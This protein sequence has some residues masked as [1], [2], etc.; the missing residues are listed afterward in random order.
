VLAGLNPG[1]GSLALYGTLAV[2]GS[3]V[4]YAVASLYGQKRVARVSGPVLAAS[5]TLFGALVLI[6][7]AAIDPPTQ[8]PGWH[9]IA[10][11]TALTVLGTAFAQLVLYRMLRLHGSSRTT[12]VTYL[13]PIMAL[14]Y[15]ALLLN[16]PITGAMIGG[17]ALILGGVALGSGKLRLA[18]RRAAAAA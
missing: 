13:M 8:V 11:L 6:P 5:S 4:S 15:G 17:L 7:F 18:R 10:A 2:I 14:G 3:S 1:G 9:A 16:E 12:L